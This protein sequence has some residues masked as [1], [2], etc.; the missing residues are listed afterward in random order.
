MRAAGEERVIPHPLRGPTPRFHPWHLNRANACQRKEGN[1][2]IGSLMWGGPPNIVRNVTAIKIARICSEFLFLFDR[3]ELRISHALWI[4]P[5]HGFL[6]FFPTLVRS[7][8]I[9]CA[10]CRS[11]L[12]AV[13]RLLLPWALVVVLVFSSRSHLLAVS[14]SHN[15]ANHATPPL[16]PR[17]CHTTAHP[18][19]RHILDY[20]C[21]EGCLGTLFESS[22][23]CFIDP[24]WCGLC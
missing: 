16:P 9:F 14:F 10:V 24:L 5:W 20:S 22:S 1:R 7:R 2:E 21:L 8:R 3:I 15:H 6:F 4:L 17:L 11:V 18:F 12:A 19:P 23:C 13:L